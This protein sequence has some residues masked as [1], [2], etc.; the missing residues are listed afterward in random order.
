MKT[1]YQILGIPEGSPIKVVKVAFRKLAL[2]YHPDKTNGDVVKT[3]E[4]LII[5]KA[6]QD[7]LEGK[8]PVKETSYSDQQYRQQSQTYQ[9]YQAKKQQY[10]QQQQQQQSWSSP[11]GFFRVG[12]MRITSKSDLEITV[13]LKNIWK[14]QGTGELSH[15]SWPVDCYGDRSG[16]LTIKKKDLQRCNYKVGLKFY[17]HSVNYIRKEYQ[18]KDPRGYFTKLYHTFKNSF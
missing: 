6:Y 4:F 11:K 18:I 12:N 14:I 3:N 5:N 10:S 13:F 16:Y 17:D 2:K 1:N 8:N 7:I 9:N 15:E